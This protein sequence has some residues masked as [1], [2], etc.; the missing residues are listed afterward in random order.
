MM[1]WQQELIADPFTPAQAC[2][3]TEGLVSYLR[4]C[5]F[6]EILDAVVSCDTILRSSDCIYEVVLG[7]IFFCFSFL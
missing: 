6:F 4:F 5:K 1:C 7:Q 2:H 3:F